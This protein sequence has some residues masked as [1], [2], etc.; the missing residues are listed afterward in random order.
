MLLKKNFTF[1]DLFAGIGGFHC[2]MK[3][4]SKK[5]QCIMASEINKEAAKVYFDNYG[6]KPLGDIK[7]ICGNKLPDYDVLC[8]GFPCQTF[9]KAGAQQGF[10]D[11]RG[12]LF[13]EIIRL[14]N[15][16]P[17]EKRPMIL[18]LEN[19]KNLITHDSCRTWRTIKRSLNQ[20]GYNVIE[21]PIV[22]G[23]KDLGIP[24]I[25][26]RAIILAVKNDIYSEPIKLNI[27]QRKNNTTSIYDVVNN[28]ITKKE[29]D[30]YALTEEQLNILK[31]WDDFYKGIKEK[32]IG[33]PVWSD[34]FGK[35]YDISIFPE[36]K[37]DFIIKNR[38]LYNNNKVFIDSWLKKWDVRNSFTPTNRKFEWQAGTDMASVFDG[39]IQFRPSG[40]RVKRP[41]ESPT[42]VAMNH[43][44]IIGKYKRF[45]T[46]KEATKLQCFPENFVFNE[47]ESEA[48]KQL[49]NAV[50]VKVIEYVF[51]TFIDYLEKE[52]RR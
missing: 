39:I 40:I 21:K 7:E 5:S 10:G 17:F 9:S 42:L 44:P 51:R 28:K 25:R 15:E 50:N 18:F 4:Y 52:T 1:I 20:C 32:V 36:W 26:D 23:P 13:Y 8:A 33:F 30:Q 19:V 27:E 12:T 16:K 29:K 47:T 24:Q 49:G 41:T 43:R 31:C 45:I 34:E 2:A 35:G 48:Y 46:L 3:E 11:P 38:Q 22:I 14:L 37:Q 6:I